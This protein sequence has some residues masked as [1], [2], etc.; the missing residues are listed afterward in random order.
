MET[1]FVMITIQ[2]TQMDVIQSVEPRNQVGFVQLLLEENQFVQHNVLL[3]IL[4][5][6]ELILAQILTQIMGT[7]VIQI[8]NKN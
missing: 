4:M 5:L 6:L 3:Q 2:P 7:D 1:K 8:V